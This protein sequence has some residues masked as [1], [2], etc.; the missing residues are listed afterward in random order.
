[1]HTVYLL[2]SFICKDLLFFPTIFLL[3]CLLKLS[4]DVIFFFSAIENTTFCVYCYTITNVDLFTVKQPR[5][6]LQLQDILRLHCAS[7]RTLVLLN[8]HSNFLL[9]LPSLSLSSFPSH[10]SIT[11]IRVHSYSLSSLFVCLSLFPKGT[12]IRNQYM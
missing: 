8:S 1:M 12:N 3:S 7:E 9:S 6:S 11:L 2:H 5:T 10:T 4:I